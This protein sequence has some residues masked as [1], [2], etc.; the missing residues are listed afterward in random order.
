MTNRTLRTFAAALLAMAFVPASAG[1]V[2]MEGRGIAANR[3]GVRA[4][5][6][7]RV[8]KRD[9]NPPVGTFEA[10]FPIRN[11]ARVVISTDAPRYA[12]GVRNYGRFSG[13]GTATVITAQG[14]RV[15]EGMVFVSMWDNG[16]NSGQTKDRLRIRFIRDPFGTP[17]HDFFYEGAVVDGNLV[18]RTS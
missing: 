7:F 13:P 4:N 16:D 5:F 18:V 6:A 14:R 1:S 10:A 11:D 12:A 3:N 8:A 17:E 9:N 2:L 15:V